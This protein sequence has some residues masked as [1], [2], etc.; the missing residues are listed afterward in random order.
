MK[1]T[2]KIQNPVFTTGIWAWNLVGRGLQI[3]Y[4]TGCN[5]IS[6]WVASL[7]PPVFERTREYYNL[8]AREC[9]RTPGTVFT[10][11]AKWK[12]PHLFEPSW[13]LS[14]PRFEG[15]YLPYE[16]WLMG[17]WA[18]DVQFFSFKLVSST[19][20]RHT[21]KRKVGIPLVLKLSLM[22]GELSRPFEYIKVFFYKA[23]Q[24]DF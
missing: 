13:H 10:V 24:G 1:I 22:S 7:F 8:P 4:K 11:R 16:G 19:N 21:V 20:L 17:L 2:R 23:Q 5:F 6:Q 18:I 9:Q 3:L 15:P 12:F 14:N